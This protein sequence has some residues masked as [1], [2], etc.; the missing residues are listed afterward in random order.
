MKR[1]I[2]VFLIGAAILAG[3][4]VAAY[5][6]SAQG[7]AI[8][9]GAGG[10]PIFTQGTYLNICVSESNESQSYVEEHSTELG[11]CAAGYIQYTVPVDPARLPLNQPSIS[12]TTTATSSDDVTVIYPGTQDVASCS[13]SDFLKLTAYSNEG[14]AIS[15]TGW[16]VS[17]LSGLSVDGLAGLGTAELSGSGLTAGTYEVTVTA[18]DSNG[19]SGH[20][21]FAVV[22]PACS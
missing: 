4:G 2:S 12:S 18:T 1:Q 14:Y 5:A 20:T 19:I 3:T 21:Q 6:Q 17:G 22:V 16:S 15:D 7:P 9:T 8:G 11:N 10:G 13:P